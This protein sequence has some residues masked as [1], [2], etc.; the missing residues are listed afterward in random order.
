MNVDNSSSIKTLPDKALVR[1]YQIDP[2][3]KYSEELLSRYK[4]FILKTIKDWN[5]SNASHAKLVSKSD[6]EDAVQY[7]N[8]AVMLFMSR[9]KD[10][11]KVKNVSVTIKS[12]VYTTLNKYY[13]HRKYEDDVEE[14]D[15]SFSNFNYG[16]SLQT[17]TVSIENNDNF[18]AEFDI[19]LYY[20]YKLGYNAYKIGLMISKAKV[21]RH[22]DIMV[23]R[24]INQILNQLR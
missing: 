16:Q 13:R 9:C 6:F 24:L 5:D 2:D 19:L 15:D 18:F 4:N 23:S 10:I 22:F 20:K 8:L 21:R 12:Y 11:S 3:Q 14:I 7:S 17:E 1:L